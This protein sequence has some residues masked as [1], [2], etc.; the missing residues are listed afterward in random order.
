[1]VLVW[2]TLK[3]GQ[4]QRD[5]KMGCHTSGGYFYCSMLLPAGGAI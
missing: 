5:K 3:G 4:N 2:L 1:M